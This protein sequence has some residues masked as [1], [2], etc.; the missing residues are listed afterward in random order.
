MNKQKPRGWQSTSCKRP[1]QINVFSFA[2][3]PM[4]LQKRVG[5]QQYIF[6]R[7]RCQFSG[8]CLVATG[9]LHQLAVQ[10]WPSRRE[11]PVWTALTT[12]QPRFKDLWQKLLSTLQPK[13]SQHCDQLKEV[14]WWKPCHNSNKKNQQPTNLKQN[15]KSQCNKKKK[16]RSSIVLT[17][18]MT[19][20][21]TLW[22][23]TAETYRK[24]CETLLSLLAPLES[25]TGTNKQWPWGIYL[26]CSLASLSQQVLPC[27]DVY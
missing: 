26:L 15:K 24:R 13:L 2:S 20:W 7:Q 8:H 22:Q 18:V 25:R 11:I 1:Q 16:Q 10:S 5:R 3:Q 19:R 23:N 6:V 17:S 14:L 21:S 27:G 4:I 9:K 12:P